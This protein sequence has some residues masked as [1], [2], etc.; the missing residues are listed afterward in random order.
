MSE[1][2]EQK[3]HARLRTLDDYVAKGL[4]RADEADAERLALRKRLLAIAMPDVPAPSMPWRARLRALLLMGLVVSVITAWLLWGN[5]GLRPKA[6]EMLAVAQGA[7]A[8]AP[9]HDIAAPRVAPGSTPPASAASAPGAC[10]RPCIAVQ[11]DLAIGL[12]RH[13]DPAATVFIEAR[14]PGDTGLPLAAVRKN[15]GDLPL[16]VVL[17]LNQAVGDPARFAQAQALQISARFSRSGRGRV[18]PED[19]TVVTP[20]VPMGAEGL[21]LVVD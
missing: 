3:I 21:W 14:L 1:T 8:P 17:D 7:Q 9:A 6:V 12:K 19:R 15:A 16:R 2:E 18:E 5:A 10:T 4:M 11:V 20:V 13:L